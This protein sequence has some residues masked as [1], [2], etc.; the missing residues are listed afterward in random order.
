M[1]MARPLQTLLTLREE[2]I[3]NRSMPKERIRFGGLKGMSD[4][5][6]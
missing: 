5:S 4:P 2:R 3:L 6:A 1:A